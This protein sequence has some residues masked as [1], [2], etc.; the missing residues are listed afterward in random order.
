[1]LWKISFVAVALILSVFFMVSRSTNERAS[2]AH[3]EF[4]ASDAHVFVGD[5]PLVIPFVALPGYV[6]I[7]PSFTLDREAAKQAAKKRLEDFRAV[8]ASPNTA[9]A[10]DK[11]I[12]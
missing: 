12:C 7:G 2:R 1:M 3:I 5:V 6:A 9:P 11:L 10:V 4:L 8:A